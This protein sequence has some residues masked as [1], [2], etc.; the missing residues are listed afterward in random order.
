MTAMSRAK[1]TDSLRAIDLMRTGGM[2]VQM[3][4]RDGLHWY[5]VPGGEVTPRIAGELLA[6]PDVQPSRDGL[7]PGISQTFRLR[8]AS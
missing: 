8:A 4:A 1:I 2:L 3:H 5:V 6:R 7:F